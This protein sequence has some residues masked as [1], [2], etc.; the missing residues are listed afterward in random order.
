M[1]AAGVVVDPPRLDEGPGRRQAPEE[2][3]V[4]ALVA[5]A[6]IQAFDKTVLL[7]LAGGDVVPLDCTLFLPAQDGVRGQLGAVA[8][9][10]DGS[11]ALGRRAK[12]C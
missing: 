6:P 4:Q 9:R 5:Q 12:P 3:L 2:M 8:H 11:T 7:R 10:E 1:G